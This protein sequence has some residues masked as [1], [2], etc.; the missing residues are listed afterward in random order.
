M[1]AYQEEP[2]PRTQLCLCFDVSHPCNRS[3]C[4]TFALYSKEGVSSRLQIISSAQLNN[5][6]R[7][8]R[9]LLIVGLRCKTYRCQIVC[10]AMP[11]RSAEPGAKMHHLPGGSPSNNAFWYQAPW[12]ITLCCPCH[13]AFCVNSQAHVQMVQVVRDPVHDCSYH[14]CCFPTCR[15]DCDW[16]SV[17]GHRGESSVPPG[18]YPEPCTANVQHVNK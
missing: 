11:S 10:F 15:H 8:I 7:I 5:R 16:Q 12:N 4:L 2:A 3:L 6:L 18:L 1:L 13:K 9:V 14:S 17:P